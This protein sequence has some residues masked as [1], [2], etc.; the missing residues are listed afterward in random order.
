VGETTLTSAEILHRGYAG[1]E[2]KLLSLGA[3]LNYVE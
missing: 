3:D 2:E 1:L